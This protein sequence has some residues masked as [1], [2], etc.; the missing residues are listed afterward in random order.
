MERT[1]GRESESEEPWCDTMK[2]STTP[3]LLTGQTRPYSL[4]DVRSPISRNRRLPKVM[5]VPTEWAFSGCVKFVSGERR[6]EQ[7]AVAGDEFH[8]HA[9]DGQSVADFGQDMVAFFAKRAVGVE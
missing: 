6:L 1:K 7:V 2:T 9:L 8:F 5:R 4:S 3:S